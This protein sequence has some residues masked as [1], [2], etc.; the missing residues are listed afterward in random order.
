MVGSRAP[1]L[2]TWIPDMFD[3]DEDFAP[4]ILR[5]STFHAGPGIRNEIMCDNVEI[6]DK[7]SRI[8]N[9]DLKPDIF[10]RN[11]INASKL[12]V[13]PVK[14]LFLGS[15]YYYFCAVMKARLQKNIF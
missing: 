3:Y 13:L 8:R 7:T 9:S 15:K 2:G 1:D 4:E 5:S 10:S 12:I 6:R 14:I 11:F